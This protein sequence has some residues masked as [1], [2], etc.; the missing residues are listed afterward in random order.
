MSEHSK[1]AKAFQ[2]NAAFFDLDGTLTPVDTLPFWLAQLKGWRR[3]TAAYA[4]AVTIG[5][6]RDYPGADDRKGRIKA[7]ALKRLIRGITQSDA[8]RAGHKISE[9]LTWNHDM[10]AKMQAHKENGDKVV[11]V[12]GSP[13]IYIRPMLNRFCIIDNVIATPLMTDKMDRLTGEMGRNCVRAAKAEAV[14][15]YLEKH[16]EITH[17]TGY[18]N[19][20]HDKAFLAL[21]DEHHTV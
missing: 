3:V 12:T 18:G 19:L 21:M 2:G 17:K 4:Y 10:I 5:Q 13:K 11:I 16:P 14:Q 1:K 15:A 20:P 9:S 8:C 7:A 6:W